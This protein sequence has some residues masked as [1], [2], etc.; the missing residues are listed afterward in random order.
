MRHTID[1]HSTDVAG[2]LAPAAPSSP[3]AVG[4]SSQM[5]SL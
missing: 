5:G 3:V 2:P 1:V 4:E